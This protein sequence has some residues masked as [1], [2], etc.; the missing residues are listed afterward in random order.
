MDPS[1]RKLPEEFLERVRALVPCSALPGVLKSFI[2]PKPVTFRINTLK[3]MRETTRMVSP[4][5][6][7]ATREAV[8]AELTEAGFQLE[9][10]PWYADAFIV[11][12]GEQRHL[13]ATTLYADG[14]IYL[15]GLSSMLPPLAL[16]PQPGETILDLTAAPGSKTTQLACLMRNEG[17]ILA[18]EEDAV[19][20]DLLKANLVRQGVTTAKVMHGDGA[21]I[22]SRHPGYFD[23]I[24]LDAPCS[25]EGR[26]CAR[27]PRTYR[28]WS[29]KT[30]REMA[31]R[32]HRLLKAAVTA[33][34]PGGVVVYSTCTLAPEENEAVVTAVLQAFRGELTVEPLRVAVRHATT[35]LARW[36]GLTFDPAVRQARRILPTPE[37][38][39]FFLAKIR[40]DNT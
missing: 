3:I 28:F 21:R 1:L 26:I 15:Q 13:E 29:L 24:L 25:A 36:E 37:M 12:R 39:G 18:V 7:I 4:P 30:V 31:R 17:T 32:Q 38:E 22:A 19:R 2:T 11:R 23:R 34:K 27:Q 14:A 33:L 10:V 6:A 20:V 8:R 5:L 40:L 9:R 16:N 35:G